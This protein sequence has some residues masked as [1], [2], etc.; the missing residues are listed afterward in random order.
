[1]HALSGEGTREALFGGF[2]PIEDGCLARVRKSVETV[3]LGKL[4]HILHGGRTGH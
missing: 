4:L 3:G 1:M 2:M